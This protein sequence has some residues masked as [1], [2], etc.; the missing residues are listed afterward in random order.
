MTVF[1]RLEKWLTDDGRRE[2]RLGRC[3]GQGYTVWLTDLAGMHGRTFYG[4]SV[5]RIGQPVW[6]LEKTLDEALKREGY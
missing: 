6:N 3:G 4:D 5:E 1:E 2:A